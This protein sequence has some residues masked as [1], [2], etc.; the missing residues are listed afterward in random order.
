MRIFLSICLCIICCTAFSQ[1]TKKK[2]QK[3]SQPVQQS[4][5]N[6]LNP[7]EPNVK[8]TERKSTKS[9]K[10]NAPT[11]NLEQQYYERMEDVAKSRRKAEREMLKP[12]YSDPMYFGHKKMPKKHSRKKM[13]FCKECGI[14]H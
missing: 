14:R 3:Q 10:S 1:S 6:S 8:Y 11:Y 5:P 12:Q 7:Y 2:K 4:G 13:K 9:K